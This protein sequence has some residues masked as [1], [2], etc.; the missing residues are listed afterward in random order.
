MDEHGFE[1]RLRHLEHVLLGQQNSQYSKTTKENILKRVNIIQKELD[2][3]YKNNK[4][5]KDFVEKCMFSSIY[6][7]VFTCSNLVYTR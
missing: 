7:I 2:S 5:I 6:A 4:P 3:V 1:A